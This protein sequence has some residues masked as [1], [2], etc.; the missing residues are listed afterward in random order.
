MDTL[1]ILIMNHIV[2]PF[3]LKW[4]FFWGQ[5]KTLEVSF[6]DLTCLCFPQSF[7]YL[8]EKNILQEKSFLCVGDVWGERLKKKE[9]KYFLNHQ[10]KKS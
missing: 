1:L 2:F 6:R 8:I 3:L 4:L 9:E 5:C 7:R 10:R